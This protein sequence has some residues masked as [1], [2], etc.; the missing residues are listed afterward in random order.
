MAKVLLVVRA[1]GALMG[2]VVPVNPLSA[3][4]QMPSRRSGA[5]KE[6]EPATIEGSA[7]QGLDGP[8]VGRAD[9]ASRRHRFRPTDGTKA[10]HHY[11]L[12]R[13]TT[14]TPEHRYA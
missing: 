10:H 4:A 2:S 7:G 13:L 6:Q 8:P 11:A 3:Q 14:D 1:F 9:I 5:D 12:I